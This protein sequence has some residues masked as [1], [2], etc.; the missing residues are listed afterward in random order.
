M[1]LQSQASLMTE[2]LQTPSPYTCSPQENRIAELPSP[3]P[4]Y[5]A[6]QRSSCREQKLGESPQCWNEPRAPNRSLE[7]LTRTASLSS[8]P[9]SLT[10]SLTSS[11]TSSITSLHISEDYQSCHGSVQSLMS[12]DP[13]DMPQTRNGSLT[14]TC[15]GSLTHNGSS[16]TDLPPK[17]RNGY[18]RP[19]ALDARALYSCEA[20]HSHE[21]SFLQGAIFTNVYPSVEPGWL[22]ATLDDRTGLIPENYIIYI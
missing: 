4:E 17:H 22:Q 12:L 21:L 2:S 19:G 6:V 9:A 1:P 5:T 3:S 15:N 16:L 8:L 20:E 14:Q 11:I 10:S 18:E 7:H 13:R